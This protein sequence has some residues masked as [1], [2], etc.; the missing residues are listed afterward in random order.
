MPYRM[1][2]GEFCREVRKV[3]R[4]LPRQFH[5]YLENVVVDVQE[6]PTR[7]DLESAGMEGGKEAEEELLGL[8]VGTPLPD[9]G[10]G[11]HALNRIL[12]YRRPIEQTSRSLRE[13]REQ[14]RDTVLHELA[15]HFG[16]SEEDLIPFEDRRWRERD[17]DD[18]DS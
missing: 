13:L 8:F 16:Y 15:H 9:V 17:S 12:I 5:P 4:T 14:I 1:T 2:F 3:L 10:H 11:E 7:A 18:A 6:V